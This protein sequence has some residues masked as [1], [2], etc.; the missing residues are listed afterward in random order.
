MYD[1]GKMTGKYVSDFS[2]PDL[3]GH[4]RHIV[5]PHLGASTEEAEENSAAM[6]AETIISFLETGE[7]P[8]CRGMAVHWIILESMTKDICTVLENMTGCYWLLICRI[9]HVKRLHALFC[10]PIR[11]RY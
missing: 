5:L 7:D 9:V 8:S 10:V 3:M 2:D 4:P 6:A 11:L 1:S